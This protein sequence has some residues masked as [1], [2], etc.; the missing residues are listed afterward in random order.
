MRLSLILLLA[1][2]YLLE[3]GLS[4]SLMALVFLAG[5]LS[6]LVVQP[7]IG[8]LIVPLAFNFKITLTNP[9]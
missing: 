2:P 6:A 9:S 4:K 5:P 3:L 8:R 7:I 1:P